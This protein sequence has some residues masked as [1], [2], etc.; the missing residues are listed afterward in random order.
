M[1]RRAR[2]GHSAER[3]RHADQLGRQLVV[4]LVRRR[5]RG[6]ELDHPRP[7]PAISRRRTGP[8]P[9]GRRPRRATNRRSLDIPRGYTPG[10]AK[11]MISMPDDLLARVDTEAKRRATT[12]SGLL[13][14]AVTRELERRDP[15][16]MDAP[17]ARLR[18]SF[19]NAGPFG[20][21]H[22]IRPERDGH[23]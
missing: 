23:H 11:V 5:L 13:A 19:R 3:G 15:E 20:W 14:L 21:A 9:P 8:A 22:L 10:M 1:G 12:R 7:P 18:E 6:V 16:A 4:P 17:I 2:R